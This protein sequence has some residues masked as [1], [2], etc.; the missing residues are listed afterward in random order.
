MKVGELFACEF[1]DDSPYILACG[2]SKGE[3]AV[4]DIQENK[5]IVRQFLG[6]EEVNKLVE[7]EAE[8]KD[9]IGDDEDNEMKPADDSDSSS[10]NDSGVIKPDKSKKTATSVKQE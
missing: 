9:V 6:E 10:H 4:W 8:M 2:G 1:Y 7:E 3:L 5:Q